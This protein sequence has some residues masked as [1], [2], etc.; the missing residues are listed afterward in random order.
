MIR[1]I[2]ASIILVLTSCAQLDG[3]TVGRQDDYSNAAMSW[4]GA[5]IRE[6]VAVW[7]SPNMD[8]GPNKTGQAGC[9]WWRQFKG[10]ASGEGPLE[11]H[12]EV[13]ARYDEAGVI[14]EIDVRRSRECHRLFG[15]E[16]LDRMTRRTSEKE[17]TGIEK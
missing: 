14:T 8:C 10:I 5:E 7:P 11:H 2:I 13:I 6:M 17:R 16:Q 1:I 9:V 12:C 15:N 4:L 3:G